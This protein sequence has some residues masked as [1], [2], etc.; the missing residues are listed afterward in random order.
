MAAAA[1]LILSCVFMNAQPAAGSDSSAQAVTAS[2][3]MDESSMHLDSVQPSSGNTQNSSD[4][5]REYSLNDTGT[6]YT[7]IGAFIKMVLVL[8]VFVVAIMLLFKFIKKQN[9]PAADE[10]NPFV[11]KVFQLTLSPGKTVQIVTLVDNAYVLGV[12]DSNVNLIEKITDR[13]MVN[14]LNL[15]ADKNSVQ[16]KPKSFAELLDIFMPNRRKR[17]ASASSGSDE[18]LN[19]LKDKLKGMED[20]TK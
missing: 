9:A 5:E 15:Y 3:S 10:D 12:S 7:G 8:G 18:I 20:E 1:A 6:T 4:S 19:G 13:E 14:A 17:E 16:A 11:R 2:S